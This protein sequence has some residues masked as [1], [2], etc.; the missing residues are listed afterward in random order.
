MNNESESPYALLTK[1]Y[2]NGRIPFRVWF[3]SA[4]VGAASMIV[5]NLVQQ[6]PFLQ[7]FF[8]LFFINLAVTIPVFVAQ[9]HFVGLALQRK[10]EQAKKVLMTVLLISWTIT[11][12]CM[13]W[14]MTSL[15]EN[16]NSGVALMTCNFIIQLI[17]WWILSFLLFRVK[18]AQ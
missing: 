1:R 2:V 8:S 5:Y 15:Y 17:A 10:P 7:G 14:I 4:L 11:A 6:G 16:W 3:F 13:V 9:A 18:E 12:L